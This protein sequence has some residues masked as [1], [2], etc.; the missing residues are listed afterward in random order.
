LDARRCKQVYSRA[1]LQMPKSGKYTA[2]AN[3]GPSH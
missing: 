2:W 3:G 1:A